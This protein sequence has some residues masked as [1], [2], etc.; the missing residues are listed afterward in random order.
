MNGFRL[1]DRVLLNLEQRI[2]KKLIIRMTVSM[3]RGAALTFS[4]LCMTTIKEMYQGGG[5]WEYVL[6]FHFFCVCVCKTQR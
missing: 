6:S 3:S 5:W 2:G 1:S 4:S